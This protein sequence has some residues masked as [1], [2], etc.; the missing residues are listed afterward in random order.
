MNLIK[1]K[2]QRTHKFQVDPQAKDKIIARAKSSILRKPIPPE[3]NRFLEAIERVEKSTDISLFDH[4]IKR[5]FSSDTVLIN[6][7]KKLIPDLKRTENSLSVNGNLNLSYMSDKEL[8]DAVGEI[9]Q[10]LGDSE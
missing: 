8:K 10:K 6:V 4:A 1:T 3:L 5:A 2:G 9:L 7:L